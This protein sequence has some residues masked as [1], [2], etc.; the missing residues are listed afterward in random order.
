[1]PV[2]REPFAEIRLRFMTKHM[3]VL[4]AIQARGITEERV[5]EAETRVVT[6]VSF[7][8]LRNTRYRQP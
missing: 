1:V 6:G 3:E 4:K 7:S 2:H 5:T 8:K